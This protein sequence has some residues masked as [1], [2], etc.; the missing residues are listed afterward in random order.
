M[1]RSLPCYYAENVSCIDKNF[2]ASNNIE[3]L[4]VDIDNTLSLVDDMNI[5]PFAKIWLEYIKA[6]K[7]NVV[8]VSNNDLERVKPF[9]DMLGLDYINNA[10]KP[11]P[12]SFNLIL[13][14]YNVKA[15]H[16]LVVGD[17][18]PSDIIGGNSINAITVLVNPIDLSTEPKSISIERK[19]Y[20]VLIQLHKLSPFA[21]RIKK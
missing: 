20:N 14:K 7:Y 8:L 18:V 5:M 3:L 15:E 19:K 1:L 9:A 17:S 2:L 21:K 11:Q 13:N 16:C 10:N 4:I 6:L 12:E